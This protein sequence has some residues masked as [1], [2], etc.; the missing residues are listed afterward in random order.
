[1]SSKSFSFGRMALDSGSHEV[2]QICFT[3]FIEAVADSRKHFGSGLAGVCFGNLKSEFFHLRFLDKPRLKL[4]SW[5]RWCRFCFVHS[6]EHYTDFNG[7]VNNFFRKVRNTY[8]V[9]MMTHDLK[10][11]RLNLLKELRNYV[12]R[13]LK[14]SDMNPN[15]KADVSDMMME[16]QDR[17]TVRTLKV[18][19]KE[20]DKWIKEMEIEGMSEN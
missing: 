15:S 17:K 1:M 10:N 9:D 13:T 12:K 3:C 5:S 20:L 11:N 18:V 6:G 4:N 7:N 16:L 2:D 14:N 19:R 8:Q